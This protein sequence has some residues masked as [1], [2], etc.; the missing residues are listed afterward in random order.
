MTIVIVLCLEMLD[1][2]LSKT[3]YCSCEEHDPNPGENADILLGNQRV[4]FFEGLLFP[5]HRQPS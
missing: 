4:P 1:E 5:P 3:T 2:I